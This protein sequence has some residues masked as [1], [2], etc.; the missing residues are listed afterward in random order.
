MVILPLELINKI[1]T[2]REKHPVCVIL[3]NYIKTYYET[4]VHRILPEYYSHFSF[5]NWYFNIVR[6]KYI[7]VFFTRTLYLDLNIQNE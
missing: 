3:K 2:F 4:D 7:F 1:L 5:Y 6:K